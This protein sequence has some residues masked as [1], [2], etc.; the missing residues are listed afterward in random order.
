MVPKKPQETLGDRLLVLASG[1]PRI[2]N[3][4]RDDEF[5]QTFYKDKKSARA[6]PVELLHI[7][8]L[9]FNS[10]KYGPSQE[11]GYNGACLVAELVQD[12]W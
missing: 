11:N 3:L 7:P 1:I 5:K 12:W 9:N 10:Y 2:Y 4:Q 6:S 8:A